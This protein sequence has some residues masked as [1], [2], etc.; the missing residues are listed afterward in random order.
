MPRRVWSPLFCFMPLTLLVVVVVRTPCRFSRAAASRLLHTT[1]LFTLLSLCATTPHSA[2]TCTPD[3]TPF[4]FFFFSLCARCRIRTRNFQAENAPL[5]SLTQT[6]LKRNRAGEKPDSRRDRGFPLLY[7]LG[8]CECICVIC[9]VSPDCSRFSATLFNY[10]IHTRDDVVFY[11]GF[12]TYS[13]RNYNL[14]L[15]VRRLAWSHTLV[16]LLPAKRTFSARRPKIARCSARMKCVL[17]D[18]GIFALLITTQQ[19][20]NPKN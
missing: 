5:S 8:E 17:S 18:D 1:Q 4:F 20:Y 6:R 2:C 14:F 15:R 16:Q 3:K 13:S 11:R 12:L 9:A 7:F 10:K 19:N